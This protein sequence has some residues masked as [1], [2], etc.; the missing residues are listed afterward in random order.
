VNTPQNRIAALHAWQREWEGNRH[1]QAGGQSLSPCSLLPPS[2]EPLDNLEW[3]ELHVGTPC[4]L[5]PR[6][7]S[8]ILLMKISFTFLRWPPSY[9]RHFHI[10]TDFARPFLS[11]L[12]FSALRLRHAFYFCCA[13]AASAFCF[14]SFAFSSMPRF[15]CFIC[16]LRVWVSI[17]RSSARRRCLA[18]FS[19][20][21]RF[22]AGRIQAFAGRRQYDSRWLAFSALLCRIL[23]FRFSHW[24]SRLNE[25]RQADMAELYIF[26]ISFIF[27]SIVSSIELF[28]FSS[29]SLLF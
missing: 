7:I 11:F 18:S 20:A 16:R 8:L 13:I 27:S 26:I 4:T 14:I 29:S 5:L 24:L 6:H 2:A 25:L 10:E 12:L 15:H 19:A 22:S 3:T 17:F 1:L 9:F 21:R 23:M 28:S